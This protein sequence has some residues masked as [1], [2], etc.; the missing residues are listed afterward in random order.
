MPSKIHRVASRLIMLL[1]S[2]LILSLTIAFGVAQTALAI[3]SDLLPNGVLS[4]KIPQLGNVKLQARPIAFGD[5]RAGRF[6]RTLRCPAETNCRSLW[7]QSVR[8]PLPIN[9]SG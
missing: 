7:H 2:W 4:S 9:R 8:A 1:V 5:V 3:L 6:R